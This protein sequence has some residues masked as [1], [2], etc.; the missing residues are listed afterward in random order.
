[1]QSLYSLFRISPKNTKI[2]HKNMN[3]IFMRF[4]LTL[5]IYRS[6]VFLYW[7]NGR[8]Y[9]NMDTVQLLTRFGL[10]RQEANLYILLCRRGDLTGYEAA[11]LTGISRSGTYTALAGLVEKGAA[12][13]R[14]E[15]ASHYTPVPVEEFSENY[16]HNL[17]KTREQLIAQM[18]RQAAVEDGYL[19]IR[20]S[21]HILDRMRS[22]IRAAQKRLYLSA[23]PGVLEELSPALQEAVDAGRKVTLITSPEFSIEGAYLY[24]APIPDGQ[25]RLIVDS[26]R[27]LAGDARDEASS[28]VYSCQKNLVELIKESLANEI[29]LI[30]KD[31]LA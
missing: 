9:G 28:C 13:L 18:P 10:T 12:Y 20:G 14:E 8:V 31:G 11:K 2:F 27:A 17:E 4:L 23:S 30:Q 22:M 16:L 19:T 29:Q 25:V 24:S 7:N 1:M 5:L 15:A 26:S 21:R 6:I 3:Y